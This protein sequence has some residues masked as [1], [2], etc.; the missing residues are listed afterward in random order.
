MG[1]LLKKRFDCDDLPAA[2]LQRCEIFGKGASL[3]QLLLLLFN[4]SPS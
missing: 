4:Q 2:K 1:V 3:M